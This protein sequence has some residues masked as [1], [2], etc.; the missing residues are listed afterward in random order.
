MISILLFLLP[1]VSQ[2]RWC[3]WIARTESQEGPLGEKKLRIERIIEIQYYLVDFKK[4]IVVNKDALGAQSA[5]ALTKEKRTFRR[6]RSL[7]TMRLR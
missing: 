3:L 6:A 7:A 4:T 2:G 1:A 5:T